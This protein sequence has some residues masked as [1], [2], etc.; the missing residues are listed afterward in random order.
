MIHDEIFAKTTFEFRYSKSI[1]TNLLI[2]LSR[3][4]QG[5]KN[6][7]CDE[8]TYE[9][10]ARKLEYLLFYNAEGNNNDL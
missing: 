10:H 8:F 7:I 6:T 5:T 9:P 4:R 1:N 2:H 3:K